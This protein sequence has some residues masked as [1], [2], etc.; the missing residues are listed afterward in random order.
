MDARFVA[1][2]EQAFRSGQEHR[3]SAASQ[4]AL[5]AS[6]GPRWSTPLCPTVW[7]G[8]LRSAASNAIVVVAQGSAG[9]RM[10]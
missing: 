8:L 1:A 6:S 2:V 10:T 3:I 4:V 5:P 7:S 9:E